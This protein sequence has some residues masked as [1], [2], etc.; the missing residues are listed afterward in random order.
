[1]LILMLRPVFSA[2]LAFRKISQASICAPLRQWGSLNIVLV[3]P[4]NHR[5]DL[6]LTIPPPLYPGSFCSS[7][8]ERFLGDLAYAQ[9]YGPSSWC[10]AVLEAIL[11]FPGLVQP[12][13]FPRRFRAKWFWTVCK[14]LLDHVSFSDNSC[15]V[16]ENWNRGVFLAICAFTTSRL[17]P[18]FAQRSAIIWFRLSRSQILNAC[19]YTSRF[20]QFYTVQV[21]SILSSLS[22][23]PSHFHQ[24]PL[25]LKL[26]YTYV[27][28]GLEIEC[29]SVHI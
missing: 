19:Q 24:Y 16:F 22:D 13:S 10:G 25:V 27:E 29:T 18:F 4:E 11:I 26:N 8:L 14:W 20:Q 28:V 3:Q 9:L 5:E 2:V 1:M 17:D 6:Q 7:R 12:S 15:N 23:G 21:W